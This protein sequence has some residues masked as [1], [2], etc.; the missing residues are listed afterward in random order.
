MK[1]INGLS[2]LAP[3]YDG[4][5]LDLWG[6]VHDGSHLY[7]GVHD[8]LVKLHDAGKK[9]IFVSNAPRRSKKVEAVLTQLGVEP[10]LYIEAISSGEL[11]YRWLAEGKAPW[12]KRYYYIGPSKDADIAEGLDLIHADDIKI[13]DFLMNVGFGSEAQ[14]SDDWMPLL[15]AA[16]AQGLPMLCLNPDLEVVKQTGERFE[17]AG[18]L[19]Q[20]YERLGG[21]VTWF[22]KPYPEVYEYCFGK[23][24]VDKSKILA[25]GDSLETDIPGAQKAGIDS[26]LVTGGIL[27]K[28]TADAVANMCSELRL[29]PNYVTHHLTW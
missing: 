28:H 9:I 8:V 20:H 2:E 18:V 3:R 25:I 29:S 19:A 13:A 23:L 24:K 22:G 5:L 10:S 21:A 15:R 12:G 1:T 14:S 27:K 6:V 16:R 4:F 11:G 17:C 26:M 7:P